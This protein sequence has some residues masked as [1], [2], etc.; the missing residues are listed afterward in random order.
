M[1]PAQIPLGYYTHL[2]FAFSL[3]DPVSF[4]LAPMASDVA[5]L[6]GGLAALKAQQPNLEIWLSIG[7]IDSN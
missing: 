2:N 5:Q 7:K 6:Y 1:S 3:I 4:Q